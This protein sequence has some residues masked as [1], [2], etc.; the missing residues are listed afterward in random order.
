VGVIDDNIDLAG[1]IVE[2]YRVLGRTTDIVALVAR[3]RI[4]GIVIT[5]GIGELRREELILIAR[6]SGV[7][8]REWNYGEAEIVA[9][10]QS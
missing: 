7:W 1:R 9:A 5:A 6:A 4:A 10:G 2:G 3:H 8:L